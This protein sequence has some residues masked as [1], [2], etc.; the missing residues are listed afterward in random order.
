MGI[1]HNRVESPSAGLRLQ[2]EATKQYKKADNATAVIW[3]PV[4]GMLPLV[5]QRFGKLDAP[6]RMQVVFLGGSVSRRR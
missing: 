6:E 2:P 3:K 1:G 5:E 4:E